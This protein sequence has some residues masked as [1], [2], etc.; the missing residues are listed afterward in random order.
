M[1]TVT[2]DL[3]R[4][5]PKGTVNVALRRF[6]QTPSVGEQYL[7]VDGED[8]FI[9]R[10]KFVNTETHTVLMEMYWDHDSEQQHDFS[11][12]HGDVAS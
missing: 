1:K 5:G 6:S 4:R 7:A 2:V 8:R 10:I 11:I 3:N 9:G 12:F